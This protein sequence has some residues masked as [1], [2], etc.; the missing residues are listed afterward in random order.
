MLL[1]ELEAEQANVKVNEATE[2]APAADGYNQVA[3]QEGAD[4]NV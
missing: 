2:T 3:T 4:G 1:T